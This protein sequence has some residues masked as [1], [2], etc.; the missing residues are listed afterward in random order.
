MRGSE[1]AHLR[2]IALDRACERK[3]G[4]AAVGILDLGR[5]VPLDRELLAR[6]LGDD[7]GDLRAG[8]RLVARSDPVEVFAV[9]KDARRQH[10]VDHRDRHLE[11]QVRRQHAF[12]LQHA[13]HE[14]G[15]DGVARVAEAPAGIAEAHLLHAVL[16]PEPPGI[17]GIARMLPLDA[18]LVGR[19]VLDHL[20]L[21]MR[22]QHLIM[23]AADPVPPRA[24]LAIRHR[25][26]KFSK[27]RAEGLEHLLRRIE[28][29]AAH[30]QK[31]TTHPVLPA[32]A[33]VAGDNTRVFDHFDAGSPIRV[34]RGLDHA[35]RIYP[36]CALKMSELGH[37]RVRVVHLS[38][39]E[40]FLRRR[41]IAG[42]SPAMTE[43]RHRTPIASLFER[44]VL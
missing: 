12:L 23:H 19:R 22:G 36:T 30:Q 15:V 28:R 33:T 21:R 29:D 5:A 11:P 31:L 41:W 18:V 24:D 25:E 39:Q 8:R 34:T 1:I 32:L 3:A 40:A 44:N 16:D 20:E 14:I 13:E 42:S 6:N 9:G 17:G 35:S 43:E 2:Q 4:N 26:Q 10:A 7:G 38:S 27:R 37:T